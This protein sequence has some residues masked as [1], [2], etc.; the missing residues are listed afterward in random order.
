MRGRSRARILKQQA[1]TKQ[2]MTM[3]G[4][5]NQHLVT[6]TCVFALCALTALKAEGNKLPRCAKLSCGGVGWSALTRGGYPT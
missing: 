2:K 4:G 3:F 5:T 6:G 1:K